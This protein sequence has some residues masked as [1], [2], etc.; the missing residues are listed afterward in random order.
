MGFISEHICALIQIYNVCGVDDENAWDLFYDIIF[1]DSVT[2]NHV[3]QFQPMWL[4]CR[5]RRSPVRE[6]WSAILSYMGQ[7]FDKTHNQMN[8]W[9]WD[10]PCALWNDIDRSNQQTTSS[11]KVKH[12]GK[13][14][15]WYG[16]DN[17]RAM[18]E[19]P[20]GWPYKPGDFLSVT[21]LKWDEIIHEDD[22]DEYRADPGEPSGGMSCRSDG[23]DN[24]TGGGEEDMQGGQT[25]TRKEKGT[26]Y[27]KGKGKGKRKGKGKG[28]MQLNEP[29]D[30][31]ISLVSLF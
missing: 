11:A 20:S 23:D 9:R 15:S 5:I 21:P 22:D 17:P 6:W 28:M 4:H 25:G 3:A 27:W 19:P 24:D 12:P 1:L 7:M 8:N 10:N 16:S 31:M 29:Q 13:S 2:T 26:N 18:I 14:F 30:K